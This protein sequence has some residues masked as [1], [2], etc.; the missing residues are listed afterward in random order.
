[1]TCTQKKPYKVIE[2]GYKYWFMKVLSEIGGCYSC[3]NGFEFPSKTKS[4]W[5]VGKC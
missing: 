2:I 5:F 4:G 1:M 3:H